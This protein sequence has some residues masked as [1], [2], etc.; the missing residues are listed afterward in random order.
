[1][2]KHRNKIKAGGTTTIGYLGKAIGAII[3][4]APLGRDNASRLSKS[5]SFAETLPHR[6][7]RASPYLALEKPV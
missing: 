5:R 7:D 1:M 6:H 2:L 3:G 4:M